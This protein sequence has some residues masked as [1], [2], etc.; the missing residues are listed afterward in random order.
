MQGIP[1]LSERSA[2]D[3]S[4]DAR[5]L[6]LEAVVDLWGA[7]IPSVSERLSRGGVVSGAPRRDALTEIRHFGFR[8]VAT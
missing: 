8:R 4:L 3:F 2:R 6:D 1:G 7:K 5:V